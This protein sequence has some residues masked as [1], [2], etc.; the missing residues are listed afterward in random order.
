MRRLLLLL[1]MTMTTM[2]GVDEENEEGIEGEGKK[3]R[4]LP[5]QHA[6]EI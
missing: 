4:K 6:N 5:L 3:H 1:M 2:M